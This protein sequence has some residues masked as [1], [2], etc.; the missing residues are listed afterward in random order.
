MFPGSPELFLVQRERTGYAE[1][2]LRGGEQE[3]VFPFQL[4]LAGLYLIFVHQADMVI[5][6]NLFS[7]PQADALPEHLPVAHVNLPHPN[8]RTF[9]V[10][11]RHRSAVRKTGEQLFR[12]FEHVNGD[13]AFVPRRVENRIIQAD[14]V[15]RIRRRDVLASLPFDPKARRQ[16][17]F[18]MTGNRTA[19]PVPRGHQGLRR[20]MGQIKGGAAANQ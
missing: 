10:F 2:P 1:I 3:A 11:V 16:L 4:P 12:L 15:C 9:H 17:E 8:G 19:L 7:R 14:G 6:H 20:R 5:H 18:Q 13:P